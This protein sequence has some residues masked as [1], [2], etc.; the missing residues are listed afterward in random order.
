MKTTV[1]F[2][3]TL[4][5]ICA[6]IG[7]ALAVV[8][9]ITKPI[10]SVQNQKIL[11]EG[12]SSVFPGSFTF[13]KLSEPLKSK[14]PSLTIGD[15]Y[16]VKSVASTEGVVIN[17][18]S[19]GS[20]GLVTM[21]VGI[22]KDGTISGVSII[23]T[24]ETPGLGANASNPNYYVNKQTKTTFLGQ[25]TGKSVDDPLVVK[26]DIIAITA[27]TITSKAVTAGVKEALEVGSSYLKEAGK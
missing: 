24:S 16:L 15:C 13:D 21:L 11:Q 18:S 12:L 14:D 3:V 1:K 17:I 22:K 20:Q 23:G 7:G 8:Y 27:A 19:P 2:A 5:L 6:I 25:F 10:I 4:G 9:S 26:Q